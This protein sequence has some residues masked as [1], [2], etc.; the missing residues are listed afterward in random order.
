MALFLL[1]CTSCSMGFR[2]CTER[3]RS[4]NTNAASSWMSAVALK[5]ADVYRTHAG[6][7]ACVRVRV[8]LG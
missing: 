6:D 4:L 8:R 5:S 1:T 3:G 7:L 2:S